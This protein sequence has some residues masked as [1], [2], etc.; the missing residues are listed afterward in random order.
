MNHQENESP[1][2]KNR[3]RILFIAQFGVLLAI[4][5][6]FCFTVLGSLPIGPIVATLAGIPVVIA[7]ILLGTGA[8]AL[9]GLATG[10]FSLIIWTFMPP[11]PPIAFLYTPFYSLGEIPGNFWS[12]AI[13]VFP[14]VMIGVFA[15]ASHSLLSK[16]LPYQKGRGRDFWAYGVSGALGSLANTFFV[17]GGVYVFFGQQFAEVN[18]IPYAA[19]MGIIGLT[20]ATNG[21][22]EA[23]LCAIVAMAVARP[24]K[25]ILNK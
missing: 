15:G 5:T 17:L 21:L 9:L 25:I 2:K 1:V 18:Q 11:Q 19:L 8:G 24:V 23:A 12:L 14:R 6:V 3:K 22:L 10:I 4:E 7:A 16:F 20:V 13:S